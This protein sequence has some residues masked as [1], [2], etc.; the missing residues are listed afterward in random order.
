MVS[1]APRSILE[2]AAAT[3]FQHVATPVLD[4]CLAD[5]GVTGSKTLYQK[6]GA[7]IDAFRHQW[8]WSVVDVARAMRH[9]IPG[10][11]PKQSKRRPPPDADVKGPGVPED[12][13]DLVGAID[14]A[15]EAREQAAEQAGRGALVADVPDFGP[16]ERSL[17][18]ALSYEH[19]R[20]QKGRIILGK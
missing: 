19:L 11:Q 7:L 15:A 3:G 4:N 18:D 10:L 6:V 2:A 1:G 8:Q 9:V 16:V 12:I 13:A 5:I 17:L 14:A 20:Q